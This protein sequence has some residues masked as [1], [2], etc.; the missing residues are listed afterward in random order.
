MS[1]QYARLPSAP[2]ITRELRVEHDVGNLEQLSRDLRE[3]IS[4][5]VA[6]AA[7]ELG[8]IVAMFQPRAI[9]AS[10][11]LRA[12]ATASAACCS[13][14]SCSLDGRWPDWTRRTL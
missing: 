7:D 2:R 1:E 6:T 14:I 9:A 11:S 5:V 8:D 13:F 12:S 4:E 10:S 3:A